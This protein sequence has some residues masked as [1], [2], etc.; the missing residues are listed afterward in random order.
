MHHHEGK[1]LA[2]SMVLSPNNISPERKA[3]TPAFPHLSALQ[4]LLHPVSTVAEELYSTVASRHPTTAHLS[5]DRHRQH[6]PVCD[7]QQKGARPLVTAIILFVFLSQE[8]EVATRHK[9]RNEMILS[10]PPL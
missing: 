10:I 6:I 8:L 5:T 9:Y 3:T 4:P 1:V 7:Q 2:V